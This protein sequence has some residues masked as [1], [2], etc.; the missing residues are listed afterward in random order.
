MRP[1]ISRDGLNPP[2]VEVAEFEFQSSLFQLLRTS[3]RLAG[4]C[5]WILGTLLQSLT[6]P[7]NTVQ[8]RLLPVAYPSCLNPR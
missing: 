2:L 1:L 8:H 4:A 7:Q 3:F 6:L 5:F